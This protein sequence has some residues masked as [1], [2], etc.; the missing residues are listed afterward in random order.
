VRSS[1]VEHQAPFWLAK[2]LSFAT[3]TAAV[4]EA[5]VA[6]AA[7]SLCPPATPALPEAYVD[8]NVAEWYAEKVKHASARQ[9]KDA[10]H[11]PS[12]SDLLSTFKHTHVQVEWWSHR[13]D[14]NVPR[15]CKTAQPKASHKQPTKV[16]RQTKRASTK[17][18]AGYTL[19]R[20]EESAHPMEI[21]D[22][23]AAL[24]PPA[25]LL[26]ISASSLHLGHVSRRSTRSSAH[27]TTSMVRPLAHAEGDDEEPPQEGADEDREED[28]AYV[29]EQEAEAELSI[30]EDD[31]DASEEDVDDYAA[32]P[33]A[34]LSLARSLKSGLRAV[35]SAAVGEA[36]S[37]AAACSASGSGCA[38][39]SVEALPPLCESD[40][41]AFKKNAYMKDRDRTG[42]EWVPVTQLI[43]WHTPAKML[44]GLKS[45][46]TPT[47]LSKHAWNVLV[48]DLKQGSGY[49]DGA[50][51]EG[52]SRPEGKM[53]HFEGVTHDSV[54]SRYALLGVKQIMEAEDKAQM[55][56]EEVAA[57]TGGFNQLL[58]DFTR[59]Y[60]LG[61]KGMLPSR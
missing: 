18:K 50:N 25:P 40:L 19:D 28:A 12:A 34:A 55:R 32:S 5:D 4:L 7:A 24:L 58:K 8:P 47:R 3:P 27:D 41:A 57:F 30:D 29:D 16:G 52:A 6:R 31:A 43:Y 15:P 38:S 54:S 39:S 60:L 1:R 36:A 17:R 45:A 22:E 10:L 48:V 46:R 26:P 35:R 23:G 53:R 51:G 33:R 49:L 13:S 42:V 2:V 14:I 56:P 11:S 21:H 20:E 61:R 59:A 37:A 9:G 44:T